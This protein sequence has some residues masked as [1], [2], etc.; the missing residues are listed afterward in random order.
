MSITVFP[1]QEFEIT[2]S[3]ADSGLLGTIGIQIQDGEGNV[4]VVRTTDDIV[5]SPAGSGIYT[6]TLTSP[7]DAGQYIV[8][9]DTG[10][11]SPETTTAETL[12]VATTTSTLLPSEEGWMPTVNTVAILLRARTQDDDGN[13]IGNFTADTRPTGDEVQTFIALSAGNLYSCAGPWLP[14]GLWPMS[15]FAIALGA[16]L[17]IEQ[18]YWPEQINTDQSPWRQLKIMYDQV[19]LALCQAAA[20]FRP[21]DVPGPGEGEGGE[22]PLFYFGDGES[23]AADVEWDYATQRYVFRGESSIVYIWNA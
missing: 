5:E 13:E 10:I 4:V 3:G 15:Q 17:L 14:E 6:A 1:N 11:I 16:C 7:E 19:S 9:W 2:V 18:S 20:G 23:A 22:V 12:T 21:D 8:I